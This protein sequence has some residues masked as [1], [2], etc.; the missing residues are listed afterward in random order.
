MAVGWLLLGLY[1]R[2]V[3]HSTPGHRQVDLAI[4]VLTVPAYLAA[5]WASALA[6]WA[7][8]VALSRPTPT[9]GPPS[10]W[11]LLILAAVVLYPISYAFARRDKG[12]P[13]DFGGALRSATSELYE[14]PRSFAV[15]GEFLTGLAWL[16]GSLFAIVGLVIGIQY[17]LGP[18]LDGLSTDGP[19]TVPAFFIVWIGATA[20][21][22]VWTVRRLDRR[23]YRDR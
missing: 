2:R 20:A 12:R 5:G 4:V 23:R 11:P 17:V 6:G 15:L 22:T 9:P 18:R 14:Q 7:V 1:Q 21:G 10:A 13:D 16:V 19:L 8:A 3:G